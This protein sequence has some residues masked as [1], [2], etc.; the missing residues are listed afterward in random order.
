MIIKSKTLLK[1]GDVVEDSEGLQIQVTS[2]KLRKRRF[3]RD[4]YICTGLPV[5]VRR[6]CD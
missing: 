4:L 5:G 6:L 3:K 2:V 1:V